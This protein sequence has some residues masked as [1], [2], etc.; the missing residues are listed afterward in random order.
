MID[1][2]LITITG[3]NRCQSC[4]EGRRIVAHFDVEIVG[5]LIRGCALIRTEKDGLA[6]ALPQLDTQWAQRGVSF[7]DNSLRSAV[8][9]AACEAY[10]KMGGTDLPAWAMKPPQPQADA[11]VEAV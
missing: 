8:T 2:D 11:S 9:F 5:I 10:K 4:R 1:T 6:I 7:V 3:L